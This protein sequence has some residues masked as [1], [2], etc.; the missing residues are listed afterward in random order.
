VLQIA[1]SVS[2]SGQIILGGATNA[3]LL[4]YNNS[5]G[6]VTIRNTYGASAAGA[7]IN[8]DSGTL[9][10]RAG[11]SYTERMR[12]TSNDVTVTQARQGNGVGTGA[13]LLMT[14]ATTASD[15]L[16]LNF[17][18]NGVS[19]RARAAIGAVSLDT[20][21]YNCALAFYARNGPDGSELQTTDEWM[22]IGSNGFVGMGTTSLDYNLTVYNNSDVWHIVAGGSTGQVRIGGQ[23]TG[24]GVIGAYAPNSNP[25]DLLL[26]RDGGNLIVGAASLPT[27]GGKLVVSD[28]A[29]ETKVNIVNTGTGGRHYWLGS[30]NNSSGAV[31][32]G[33]FAIYDQ[34]S[35]ISRLTIDNTGNFAITQAAGK[36]TIDTTGGATVVNNGGT[37]D[38]PS[39]SGMLVVNCWAN[40]QVTVY[41]C[42]GG[43]TSVVAN[44]SGQV[45]TFA[46]NAGIAGY[47]WTSNLGSASVYG[48]FFLRTRNTA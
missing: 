11:T 1:N 6:D 30:T 16:N 10:F 9:V 24:G 32:G 46:Y 4:D 23:P 17:S 19:G 15:R 42:G 45:G 27:G 40:G 29:A 12:I 38:F 20:G 41:L 13:A 34:T 26:Q 7:L 14:T 44:V 3:L 18:M 33:K 36:Y 22:R 21:G 48:F 35:D 5:L 28:S 43:S 37:V 25:R 39:A 31:G 47:T 8:I 2:D